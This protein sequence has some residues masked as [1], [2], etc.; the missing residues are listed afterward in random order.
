MGRGM[1]ALSCFSLLHGDL[2]KML[3]YEE[4]QISTLSGEFSIGRSN[5]MADRKDSSRCTAVCRSSHLSLV[6]LS[7]QRWARIRRMIH[8]EGHSFP[9][10]IIAWQV[11][12][13]KTSGSHCDC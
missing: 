12:A 9:A 8:Q 6:Q 5:I 3:G 1:N 7:D 13:V 10:I 2:K 4:G 11:A